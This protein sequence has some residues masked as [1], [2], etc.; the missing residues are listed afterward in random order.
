MSRI[1]DAAFGRLDQDRPVRAL[2]PARRGIEHALDRIDR[3]GLR[4][5][6]RAVG[7]AVHLG[8]T[9]FVV[10]RHGVAADGDRAPDV[11]GPVRE[12]VG[13]DGG[14]VA[15]VG[16]R[17]DRLAHRHLR[18]R[19][20]R[21]RE[22][23][24]RAQAG[25]GHE[26]HGAA[27]AHLVGRDLRF[28][29]AEHLLGQAHI[30][31][32][33]LEHVVVAPARAVEVHRRDAHAFLVE[34]LRA[35]T[36][37]AADVGRMRDRS[38]EAGEFAREEDRRDDRD[39]GQ[40]AG[41]Q[42]RV[43]GDQAIALAPAGRRVGFEHGFGGA[44]HDAGEGGNPAGALGDRLAVPV[45]QHRGEVVRLAHDGREGG[46]KQRGRRLVG[47][48]DEATP[49]DFEGDGVDGFVVSG[50]HLFSCS[51]PSSWPVAPL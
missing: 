19:V 23:V 3:V 46:P 10:H 18:A 9:A 49:P 45:H 36:R 42:P 1:E 35:G 15:A 24:E 37:I 41:R 31:E 8:R 17:G 6:H 27:A 20:H 22:G 13:I 44:R 48:G 14:F 32:E 47:N 30:V 29:V 28:D 4:V 40:M 5:V 11:R 39:V 7:A 50:R 25:I 43:V 33:Q 21:L 34:L 16:N 26:V 12:A 2:V 38:R 51:G